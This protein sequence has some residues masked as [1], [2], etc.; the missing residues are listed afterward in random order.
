MSPSDALLWTYRASLLGNALLAV[1]VAR[2]LPRHRLVAGGLVAAL[3]LEVTRDLVVEA[4]LLDR[5]LFATFPVLSA[6]VVLSALAPR[7]RL[8]ALL[9]LALGVLR[10]WGEQWL[11]VPQVVAA[12]LEVGA[13][14][15]ALS[16]RRSLWVPDRAALL[17]AAGD[18]GS[19]LGPWL[20]DPRSSWDVGVLQSVAVQATLCYFQLSWV[21]AATSGGARFRSAASRSRSH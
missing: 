18:V 19:L 21:S 3:V 17:L 20:A 1:Q 6:C 7:Y 9:P 11:L 14:A 15:S 2:N 8:A 16:G 12:V 5:A 4:S 10:L 13:A